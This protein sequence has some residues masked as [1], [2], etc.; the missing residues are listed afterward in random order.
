MHPP[1]PR[2]FGPR[3]HQIVESI[4]QPANILLTADLLVYCIVHNCSFQCPILCV[5]RLVRQEA[6]IFSIAKI[7]L[8]QHAH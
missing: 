6:G 4:D 3:I 5:Q 7:V 2:R 1:N 8:L